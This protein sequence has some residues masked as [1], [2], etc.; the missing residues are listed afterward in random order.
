M[1]H[2]THI[3]VLAWAT[4]VSAAAFAGD[5]IPAAVH[6]SSTKSIELPMDIGDDAMWRP[7][8]R[9]TTRRLATNAATVFRIGDV[10]VSLAVMRL[11]LK[12]RPEGGMLIQ[13]TPDDRVLV[14]LVI[15]PLP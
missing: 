3:L 5:I 2:F 6:E 8:P 13:N 1:K 9:C 7:C 14:A 10:P 4:C 11:E 15:D 12:R